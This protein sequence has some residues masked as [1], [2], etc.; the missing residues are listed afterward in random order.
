ME[1]PDQLPCFDLLQSDRKHMC[2]NEDGTTSRHAIWMAITGIHHKGEPNRR[3]VNT[4]CEK[5]RKE[6]TWHGM[7]WS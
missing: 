2:V 6:K 3:Q 7:A 5:K 4:R 1:I